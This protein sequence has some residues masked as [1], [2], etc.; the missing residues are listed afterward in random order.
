MLS[1]PSG[2]AA[3]TVAQEANGAIQA[4]RSFRA[5]KKSLGSRPGQTLHHVVEQCQANAV[6]SGISAERLNSTDNLMFLADDVHDAI[7]AAYSTKPFGSTM[8][9]RDSLNGLP[10]EAQHDIG[11][12]IVQQ[13]LMGALK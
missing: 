9:L 2:V 5:A 12:A 7:S 6:R 3:R 13:A 11:M 1:A 4:F 10:F 8:T